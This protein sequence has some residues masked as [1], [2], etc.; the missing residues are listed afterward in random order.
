MHS[1]ALG[2]LPR[3]MFGNREMYTSRYPAEKAQ[4]PANGVIRGTPHSDASCRRRAMFSAAPNNSAALSSHQPSGAG[5]SRRG[6]STGP[7]G[8]DCGVGRNG[9]YSRWSMSVLLSHIISL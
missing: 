4:N 9:E 3:F 2:L 1:S 8:V 5:A 6:L 7:W